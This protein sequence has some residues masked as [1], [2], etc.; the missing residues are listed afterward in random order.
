MQY[1]V[2]FDGSQVA[3]DCLKW[4][5]KQANAAEDHI[6]I[7]HSMMGGPN[8]PR[9]DFETAERNLKQARQQVEKAHISCEADLSVRGM[10]P[11]EDIVR[12]AR[13]KDIDEIVIGVKRR[14]KVGK[15][16]F[17]STAQFVI[18]EAHCPVL[19]LK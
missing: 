9:R 11:G 13:E 12:Y 3:R 8:M 7:V 19:T 1:L 4:S 2:C 15:M 6:C 5:I 18:L 16:F 17:G 10:E 14:S